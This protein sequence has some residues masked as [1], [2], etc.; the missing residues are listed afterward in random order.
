MRMIWVYLYF[1]ELKELFFFVLGVLG[2]V[3]MEYPVEE[4][5]EQKPKQVWTCFE[6]CLV[7]YLLAL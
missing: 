6:G 7:A 5:Y 4:M 1:S 3:G 2:S